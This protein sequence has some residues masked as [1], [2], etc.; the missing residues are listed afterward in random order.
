MDIHENYDTEQ[1]KNDLFQFLP[2]QSHPPAKV[3]Y[4]YQVLPA[5]H[6]IIPAGTLI[7]PEKNSK[8]AGLSWYSESAFGGK[9]EA[10]F[11]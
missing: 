9:T 1:F 8:G 6:K 3:F 7:P 2:V 4:L 10:Y 5:N 11:L